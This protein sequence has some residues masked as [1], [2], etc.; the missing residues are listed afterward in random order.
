MFYCR[1]TPWLALCLLLLCSCSSMGLKDARTAFHGGEM[2]AAADLLAQTDDIASQDT[3]LFYMDSGLIQHH[4]GNFQRSIELLLRA[5]ALMKEQ[6]Q[7]KITEQSAALLVSDQVLDYT[8]EYSERLWVHTLLM[9]NF[10]LLYQYEDALVEAKQALE[11]FQSYP[12]ALENALFSRALIALCFENMQKFS[13]ARLEYE[14][15]AQQLGVEVASLQGPHD[16]NQGEL[17]L[18]VSQGRIA[19]KTSV[20]IIVPPSIRISLPRYLSSEPPLPPS[21]QEEGQNLTPLLM[22][23]DMAEVARQSLKARS[24]EYI[25]RQTIRATSKEAM[26]RAIGEHNDLAA[27]V[28]RVILLLLEEADTR[29]WETLPASLHLIRLSLAPGRHD[30]DIFSGQA[31][32]PA[33]QSHTLQDINITAG[34]KVYYSLYF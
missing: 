28:T 19:R 31:G 32:I 33:N 2:A 34:Q 5:A 27:I 8:G 23:T 22:T 14:K 10:L 4:L 6:E 1:A 18:F 25:T 15:L 30:I 16:L 24:V 12:L 7:L 17:I 21:F 9:M 20:N 26:A 3:L 13:D 11:L 29:S